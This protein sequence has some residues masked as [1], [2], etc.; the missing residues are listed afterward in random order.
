MAT[1]KSSEKQFQERVKASA[2]KIWLAGL[3]AFAVAEQEGGKMF[4][5]LV[6]KGE[7]YEEMG[8]E[9]FEQVRERVESF[10]EAARD[11]AGEVAGKVEKGAGEAWDK[12]GGGVDD[13]VMSALHKVGV[14][15]RTEITRLTRRIE[16][17]TALVEKKA[18]TRGKATTAGK[19]TAGKKTTARKTA[20]K[21]AARKPRQAG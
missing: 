6:K 2:N 15:T 18:S 9:R 12:V 10:A 13:A 3:G 19:K 11:K 4:K 5:N 1:R 20:R 16:E 21:P 8:R 14:P 7:S 17:L